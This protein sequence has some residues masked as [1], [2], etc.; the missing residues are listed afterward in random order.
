VH[1]AARGGSSPHRSTRHVKNRID[2]L[3]V[4]VQDVDCLGSRQHDQLNLAAFG[5]ALHLLHHWQSAVNPGADNELAA[6]P[7]DLF[8]Y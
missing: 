2:R 8:L 1:P 7:R 3:S 5:F 4:R 6:L